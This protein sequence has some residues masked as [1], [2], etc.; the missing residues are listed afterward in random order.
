M[1]TIDR[2]FRRESIWAIEPKL[3][4]SKHVRHWGVFAYSFL[5]RLKHF[6]VPITTNLLFGIEMTYGNDIERLLSLD[7]K[8]Q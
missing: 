5:L 4:F 1:L 6:Q 7:S 2:S 8:R 3:E